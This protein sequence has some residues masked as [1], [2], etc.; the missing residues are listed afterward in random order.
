MNNNLT[1]EQMRMASEAKNPEELAA[2]AKENGID[3]SAEQANA[4]FERLNA[5]GELSDNE[6]DNVSG[7]YCGGGDHQPPRDRDLGG[8]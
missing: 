2:L 5:S 8:F 1:P 3:L 6:L 7:G 4:Y